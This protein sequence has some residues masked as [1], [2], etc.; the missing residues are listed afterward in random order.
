MIIE[1]V[2]ICKLGKDCE[3]DKL[4]QLCELLNSLG[5][6]PITLEYSCNRSRMVT[7]TVKQN[8]KLL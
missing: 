7:V 8:K 3:A 2:E 1:E 6:E 4:A 5:D